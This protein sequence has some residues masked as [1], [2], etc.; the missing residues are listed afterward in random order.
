MRLLVIEQAYIMASLHYLENEIY[1]LFI[2]CLPER[3]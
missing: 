1:P 2:L 3:N